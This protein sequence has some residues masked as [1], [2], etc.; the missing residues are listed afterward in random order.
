MEAVEDADEWL[1][2]IILC[3]F[4]IEIYRTHKT[5]STEI[6]RYRECNGLTHV[7]DTQTEHYN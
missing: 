6:C 4:V 7:Q 1:R 5:V 3:N 2:Y